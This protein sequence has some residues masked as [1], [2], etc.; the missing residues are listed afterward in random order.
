MPLFAVCFPN[1][2][3]RYLTGVLQPVSAQVSLPVYPILESPT[4]RKGVESLQR[5]RERMMRRG[6]VL[7]VGGA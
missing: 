2:R 6:E 4:T 3:C 7:W 1:T 5:E